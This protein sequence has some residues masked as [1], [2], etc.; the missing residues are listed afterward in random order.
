M[1]I[2]VSF[3]AT[4]VYTR[5]KK[6]LKYYFCNMKLSFKM[7][8]KK[9]KNLLT[10]KKEQAGSFFQ[11]FEKIGFSLLALLN[12]CF[13]HF[14]DSY[15]IIC[16]EAENYNNFLASIKKLFANFQGR[17][18]RRTCSE[19]WQSLKRPFSKRGQKCE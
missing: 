19:Q 10:R 13:V 5:N 1:I 12:P 3:H 14:L 16:S 11:H 2:N 17:L 4:F 6:W 8:R 18:S 7:R 15:W 9:Y